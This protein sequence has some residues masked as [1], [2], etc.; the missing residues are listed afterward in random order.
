MCTNLYQILI[1][2]VCTFEGTHV[3]LNY[4]YLFFKRPVQ[5]WKSLVMFFSV[6]LISTVP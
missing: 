3:V 5:R 4:F 1:L 2:Y 6:R